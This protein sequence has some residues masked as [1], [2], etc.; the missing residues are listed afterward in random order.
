VSRLSKAE[1][2]IKI[3]LIIPDIHH[4]SSDMIK[5]IGLGLHLLPVLV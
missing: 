3:D 2:I 1:T 5:C 4:E